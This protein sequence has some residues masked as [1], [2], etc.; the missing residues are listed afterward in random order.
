MG[1]LTRKK[2]SNL[3]CAYCGK[4]VVAPAGGSMTMAEMQKMMQQTGYHC[5]ACNK[6][7]C[8]PCSFAAAKA[9]GKQRF[10]CPTCGK[11]IHDRIAR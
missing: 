10:V 3:Q 6:V 8:G 7:A 2:E 1:W 9:Q 11:D 4:A 5:D